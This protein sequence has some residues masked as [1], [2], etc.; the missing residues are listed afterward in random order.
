[1]KI[2]EYFELPNGKQPCKEWLYELETSTRNKVISYV[3]RVAA[4]GA[5]RN[6][7]ALG[8]GVYEVKVK[9]GSGYRVYFGEVGKVILLLLVG[10]DKRTQFTDIMTA[11]KYWREYV[12]KR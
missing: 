8:E 2:V 4:G 1:L 11:K 10:G 9:W 7:R 5:R 6:I 12:Q 3:K